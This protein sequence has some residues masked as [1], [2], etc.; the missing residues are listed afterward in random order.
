MY[1]TVSLVNGENYGPLI[2]C[3]DNGEQ[4]LRRVSTIPR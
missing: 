4:T 3:P 2:K 1:G